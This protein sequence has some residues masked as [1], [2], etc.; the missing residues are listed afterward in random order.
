MHQ[1]GGP[2]AVNFLDFLVPGPDVVGQNRRADIDLAVR[3]V[4]PVLSEPIL[5]K[6]RGARAVVCDVIYLLPHIVQPLER[7]KG[8]LNLL[9]VVPQYTIA[10]K[11]KHLVPVHDPGK[12]DQ[13]G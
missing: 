3:C 13:S 7:F 5:N 2:D 10:V 1:R 12:F 9:S 8:E 6:F 11:E 4:V